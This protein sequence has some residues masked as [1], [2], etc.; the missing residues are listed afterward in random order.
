MSPAVYLPYTD[1]SLR[2]HQEPIEVIGSTASRMMDKGSVVGKKWSEGDIKID[3]DVVNSGYLIKQALGN[4]IVATGTPN[5]H[6]FYTTVS[7]NTPK[8]ASIVF[9]RETD[10]EQYTYMAS[11][12]LTMEVSDGIATISASLKGKFPGVT[13]GSFTPAV[14]SGTVIAF[15][16]CFMQF[17]T[18]LTAATTAAATPLSDFSVTV[19]NNLE[20]IHQTGNADVAVIRSKGFRA[21]GSYTLF[22]DS[23]TD[24]DAYYNLN[25]RAMIATFSGNANEQVRVRVSQFRLSEGEISTGL[26]DFFVIKAS[27]V[28]E[29][30]VDSGCR[31]IDW[32]IQ[33][34]K[35]SVY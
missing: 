30:V 32:R 16:S 8:T 33:N 4:E 11:D 24:R 19:A 13:S 17:G 21:T 6:T 34:D 25:K 22:F 26:D 9:S 14:T 31:M 15:P 29:D 28:A 20:M 12:E 5:T 27:F 3:L 18:T 35:S 10:T 23:V 1:I 2:G 7:G